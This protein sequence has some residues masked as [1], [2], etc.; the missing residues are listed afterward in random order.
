MAGAI[1]EMKEADIIVNGHLLTT[2]QSLTVRV[3]VS[4]MLMDLA[5]PEHMEALG[6]VGPLYKARLLEIQHMLIEE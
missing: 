1:G 2:A 5:E 4:S 6:G 3:A